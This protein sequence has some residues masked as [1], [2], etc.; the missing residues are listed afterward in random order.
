MAHCRWTPRPRTSPDRTR[1]LLSSIVRAR[2]K[3]CFT[4]ISDGIAIRRTRRCPSGPSRIRTPSVPVGDFS[5]RIVRRRIIEP[6]GR[7]CSR[8]TTIGTAWWP[9]RYWR[10]SLIATQR[11]MRFSKR[12]GSRTAS[13][14]RSR[15]RY[16]R[17][18]R[19]TPHERSTGGSCR[20]RFTPYS[21]A[22]RRFN[23]QASSA[24]SSRRPSEEC[25]GPRATS[26][27]IASSSNRAARAAGVCRPRLLRCD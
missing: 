3:L 19:L 21:M 26:P 4:A 27:R 5:P 22:R 20:H 12:R 11:S 13:S 6:H 9:P 24:S 2:W 23:C 10:T 7:C 15:S 14:P 25:V 8:A 18:L 17:P 16:S 1:S